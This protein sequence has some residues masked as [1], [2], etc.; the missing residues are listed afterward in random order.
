MLATLSVRMHNAADALQ[1]TRVSE[2]RFTVSP[3]L[4]HCILKLNLTLHSQIYEWMTDRQT[5]FIKQIIQLSHTQE[6]F[7]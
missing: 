5:V 2:Q 4:Y 6:G 7:N 3:D 1:K